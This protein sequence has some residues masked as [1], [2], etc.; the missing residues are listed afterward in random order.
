MAQLLRRPE[1]KYEGLPSTDPTLAEEVVR[2]VEIEVKYAGYI[3]REKER[4]K[5]SAKQESQKIPADFNY[6]DVRGLRFEAGE[7]LARI[8]PESL[9]QAARISGVNPSDIS[10]LEMWLKRLRESR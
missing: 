2:Q 4:I 5:V 9:R 10:I 8:K 3:K 1:I 6:G 7:K